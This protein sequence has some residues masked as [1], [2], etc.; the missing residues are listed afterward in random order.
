MKRTW[1]I[2]AVLV[3]AAIATWWGYGRYAA[4][5]PLAPDAAAAKKAAAETPSQEGVI[6]A[7]GKLLPARW[8]SLGPATGGI[9]R[10]ILVA[11][12]DQVA[13]G[14]VLLELDNSVLQSQVDAAA[15]AL[16]EAQAARDKL[17]AGATPAEL[18]AG[19]AEVSA[20]QG[21]V[22]QVQAG[23]GQSQQA[24]AAAEAQVKI[25]Q[26]QFDELAARPSPTELVE[27][28]KHVDLA[29]LALQQAQAAYDRVRGDPDIGAR[30]EA[31]ALQQSTTNL[32]SV[33]AAYATAGQGATREQ[34]AIGRAQI[35]AAR[36]QA[37]VARSQVPVAE[38]AGQSARAQLAS[39]QAALDRLKAGATAEERAMAD[40]RVRAVQAA[41]ATAQAQLRQMQVVAPFEGQMG[42]ISV[43]PGELAMPG[44][45]V[46]MLGDTRAMHVETTDLRET[47]V[48][49]LKTGMSVEVT[50]D[51]L[52]GR[53][54]QGTLARIAPMSTMEKGS[55]N[56][57]IIVEVPDL[58][59]GLRWGMTAFVNIQTK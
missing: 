28:Q 49:R 4:N 48:T 40:A 56:Y 46:L 18:A 38:A 34:L 5:R 13:P 30:P 32:E 9:V 19:Q 36:A 7:S 59:P 2:L 16:S 58:D 25:V 45:P 31:L 8:A 55:T 52:P 57:T 27:A 35:A 24:V 14:A 53:I 54:F 17:F 42:T 11:E 44:Q 37:D 12:G 29:R 39:A 21:S 6:W 20:A 26:A 23:V 43:R 33:R 10:S 41:L 47:D 1:V 22:A 50:F 3:L 15:A 51:A